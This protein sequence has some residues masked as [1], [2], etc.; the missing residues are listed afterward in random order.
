MNL[1]KTGLTLAVAC[2]VASSA[3]ATP[4]PDFTF[5]QTGYDKG[6]LSGWFSGTDQNSDGYLSTTELTDFQ[7]SFY[8]F[9]G[10]YFESLAVP[11]DQMFEGGGF[12]FKL[13]D[14]I[15]GDDPGEFVAAG[16]G[17]THT[18]GFSYETSAS[19]GVFK[20]PDDF[21]VGTTTT[22]QLVNVTPVPEPASLS[23]LLS[24]LLLAA[25]MGGRQLFVRRPS[26]VARG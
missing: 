7:F 24:G 2:G 22:E 4:A 20:S 15:L 8:A 5:T 23:M 16:I 26:A 1:R 21:P 11:V 18:A 25:L 6:E 12:L 13:D 9:D 10:S 3:W 19:G 14:N 17:G